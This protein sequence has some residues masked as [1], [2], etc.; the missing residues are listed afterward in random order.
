MEN[1]Y[2]RKSNVLISSFKVVEEFFGVLDVCV[3]ALN[4]YTEHRP[5]IYSYRVKK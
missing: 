4:V 5:C 2:Y 1:S 3:L